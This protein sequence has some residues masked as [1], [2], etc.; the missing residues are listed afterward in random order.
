M[1]KYGKIWGFR[2]NY[3]RENPDSESNILRVNTENNILFF[4]D[5]DIF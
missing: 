1:G 3:F 2:A 5:I 4:F